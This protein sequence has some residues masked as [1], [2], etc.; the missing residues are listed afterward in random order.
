ML[1]RSLQVAQGITSVGEIKSG[2]GLIN[3]L[4]DALD[5][6]NGLQVP[7]QTLPETPVNI[8]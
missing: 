8:V 2:M 7:V 6:F 5:Q 1:G 4:V 3:R